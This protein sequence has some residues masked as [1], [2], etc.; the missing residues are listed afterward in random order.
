MLRPL[1]YIPEL[2]IYVTGQPIKVQHTWDYV[3]DESNQIVT[4][5]FPVPADSTKALETARKKASQVGYTYTQGKH[6]KNKQVDIEEIKVVN[7]PNDKYQIIGLECQSNGRC[8]YKVVTPDGY[9]FNLY[10]SDLLDIILNGEIIEGGKIT[11]P[12]VWARIERKMRLVRVGSKLHARLVEDTK[13]RAIAKTPKKCIKKK[14]LVPGH[15]YEQLNGTRKVFVGFVNTIQCTWK[16]GHFYSWPSTTSSDDIQIKEVRKGMLFY[17]GSIW[18]YKPDQENNSSSYKKIKIDN[19]K[20][21]LDN[22]DSKKHRYAQ[23][24]RF[25]VTTRHRFIKDNGKKIE[26]PENAISLL[27]N[28]AR[29]ILKQ[30]ISEDKKEVRK[31]QELV[32][33]G[34]LH[35]YKIR[36]NPYLECVDLAE[37]VNIDEYP[38][39]PDIDPVFAKYIKI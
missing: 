5:V 25:E 11:T 18:I 36:R 31:K 38:A 29:D 23:M 2:V 22:K 19:L 24:Y 28:K 21:I 8:I 12:M 15:Q 14:D 9:Y 30:R 1:G 20:T 34:Q 13:R 37:K 3:G 16:G 26:I 27:R 39:G 4:P 6:V 35:N 33:L 10:G 17:T 32:N 7:E